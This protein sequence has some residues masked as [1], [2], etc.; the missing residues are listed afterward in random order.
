MKKRVICL[1]VIVIAL[2]ACGVLYFQPLSLSDLAGETDQVKIVSRELGVRNGEAYI[3]SVSYQ[4]ITPEQTRAILALLGEHPYRRTVGT[5]FSKNGAVSGLGDKTLSLYVYDD[6]SLIN[7][8]TLTSSESGK[9]F[10]NEKVYHMKTA[11]QK[12][13]M[14]QI[15]E[16][17]R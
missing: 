10:V 13:L 5:L 12:Q 8:V 11:E 9:I 4:D 7:S 6:G 1:A 15:L 16:I 17:I 3:D 14:E 2:L